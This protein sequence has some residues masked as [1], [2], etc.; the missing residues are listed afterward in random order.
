VSITA[1]PHSA[2]PSTRDCSSSAIR[3]SSATRRT[4]R[5][6]TRTIALRPQDPLTCASRPDVSSTRPMKRILTAIVL[7]AFV[8]ALIFFGKLWMVTVVAALVAGLA[9]IEFRGFAAAG[10][11]PIPL[12]WT[13]SAL[14]LFFRHLFPPARYHHRRCLRY[15]CTLRR[16]RLPHITGARSL[17][18]RGRLADAR[19]HCVSVDDPPANTQ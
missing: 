18:D 4:H 5:L 10:G 13:I 1:L 6:A 19:L 17:A 15:A 12:W 3:L 7:I 8:A 14:S 2:F 16:R 9:A 11:C